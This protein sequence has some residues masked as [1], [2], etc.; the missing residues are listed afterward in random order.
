M[1]QSLVKHGTNAGYKRELETDSVC[2]RCRNAHRVYARQHT[3]YGKAN[4]LKYGNHEVI[5]HL[6]TTGPRGSAPRPRRDGSAQQASR[7]PR[8][9]V[10]PPGDAY[11]GTGEDVTAEAR[12]EPSLG[13]RLTAGLK[14]FV[15]R[16]D[17]SYVEDN[18]QP[19][20]I[21]ESEPDPEPVGG[22][23]SEIKDDDYVVTK[24]DME[25]I[26][27]NLGTYM[28]VLGITLE[29]IDPY[30]GPILADNFDNIVGRW[31]KV[32]A[33]YPKAAKL[34]LSKDGGTIMLWIGAIQSTWPVLLAVYEHHLAKTIQTDR[35]SGVSYRVGK[36]SQN[37]HNVDATMPPQPGFD[38]TVE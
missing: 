30:C 35:K 17:G 10:E 27:D 26:E 12:S 16:N 37:G 13:D 33:R 5:D 25:L 22:D 28:S 21:H 20:Y 34:F 38:Y 23:W 9:I 11:A 31:S 24:A 15:V 6:Y 7:A 32:I 29:M 14:A 3:K 8:I 2:E 19:D 1:P 18:E 36:A 4:G